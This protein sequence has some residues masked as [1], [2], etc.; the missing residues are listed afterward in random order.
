MNGTRCKPPAKFAP[1]PHNIKYNRPSNLIPSNPV[2]A[3]ALKEVDKQIDL[4]YNLSK[5][6]P[7]KDTY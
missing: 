5:D 1:H 4:V 7:Y 6:K 2:L 3:R